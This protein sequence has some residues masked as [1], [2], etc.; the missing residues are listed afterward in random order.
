M[1]LK[2]VCVVLLAVAVAVQ[3]RPLGSDE[4]GAVVDAKDSP[5]S[6]TESVGYGTKFGKSGLDDHGFGNLGDDKV[7]Q[8]FGKLGPGFG[9]GGP[10]FASNDAVDPKEHIIGEPDI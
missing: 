3:A 4:V 6:L 2:V 8:N 9:R 5:G 1:A 10:G 7:V